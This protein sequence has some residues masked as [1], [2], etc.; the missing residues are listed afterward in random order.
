[1]EIDLKYR[2][3]K[4]SEEKQTGM[5]YL[6]K[7]VI[8]CAWLEDNM[9]YSKASIFAAKKSIELLQIIQNIA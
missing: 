3:S 5:L 4:K 6:L 9:D 2:E 8:Y 7:A 1:M